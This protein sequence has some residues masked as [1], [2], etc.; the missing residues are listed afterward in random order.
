VIL[1]YNSESMYLYLTFVIIKK[2]NFTQRIKIITFVINEKK[3]YKFSFFNN[4]L[5]N[6]N[7]KEKPQ[8]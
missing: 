3:Y 5:I 8:Q 4:K 1:F 6:N 7:K 2:N